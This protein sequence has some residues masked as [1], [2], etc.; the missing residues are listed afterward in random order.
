[1]CHEFLSTGLN[2]LK[3]CTMADTRELAH[4]LI[5]ESADAPHDSACC[6]YQH[7]LVKHRQREIS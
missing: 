5:V 2:P 3:P 1:M 4:G 6:R 7:S